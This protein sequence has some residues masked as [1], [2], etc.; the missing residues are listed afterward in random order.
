MRKVFVLGGTGFLGYHTVNELLQ[1]GYEVRS[2]S[3][4]PMP[5]ENLFP[6]TVE[7]HLGDINS[8]SDAEVLE[9]LDGIDGFVYAIGADER[10][11]PDAPAYAAFY[12]AN[13]LPTQRIA[14]LCV[15]AGVKD[16]VVFGSYFSEMATKFPQ[17]NLQNQ[18]YSG[19]RLLQELIA[20]AEGEGKMNVSSLRLPY[21]FG[22]MP[23]RTP[24][25][26]MFTQQLKGQDVAPVMKGGTAV[27]SASQVAQAAVGALE[28]GEHRRTYAVCDSN[29]SFSDF[30]T[31]IVDVLGQSET[32]HVITLPF[33]AIADQIKQ[34]D[35]H[36]ASEGKE[37]GIHMDISQKMQEEDLYLDPN[38]AF[39]ELGV[40]PEKDMKSLIVETLKHC[41]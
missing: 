40:T 35:A 8:M 23:G 11:T 21:I 25:W 18:G 31:L 39:N 1:R 15:E 37:H 5:A 13:V 24:L 16:F 41:I 22:Y 17:Y 2:L 7:N 9:L 27:I 3:L 12:K 38:I 19:T 4:P 20:F 6:A 32:T 26:S 34:I 29:I 14:R 36:A 28:K 33:E 10:W 30:N